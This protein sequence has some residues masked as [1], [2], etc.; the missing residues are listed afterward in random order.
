MA[1]WKEPN[2]AIIEETYFVFAQAK[3]YVELSY[4]RIRQLALD[5]QTSRMTGE[6]V[7]LEWCWIRDRRGTS[8]EAFYRFQ[9]RLA[10]GEPFP[11]KPPKKSSPRRN[12]TNGR[13]GARKKANR[14]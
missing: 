5:G 11:E 2:P 4:A 1:D 13:A 10:G 14:R 6:L 7:R 8:V 9:L 3:R 12:G